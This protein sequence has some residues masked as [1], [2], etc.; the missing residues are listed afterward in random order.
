[1]KL[2]NCPCKEAVRPG[3]NQNEAPFLEAVQAY[4]D[5]GIVPFHTPGH[6][7]GRGASPALVESLGLRALRIDVSDVLLSPRYNDSWT[8]ALSA[9]ERLAADLLGAD[10]CYFLANGTSGGVHA[11]V[12][13][14]AAGR[15]IIV[16]RSSHRSVIGAVILADAWPVYVDPVY[17]PELGLWLPPPPAAWERAMDAHPD[18]AAVL[19]T[20]PTYEGVALDLQ[21]VAEAA[22]ARGLAVLVDEAHGAHF[23]LHPALP[24]RALAL[25]ADLSAQSPHKLLGS[26]TQASWLLGRRGRVEQ[27]AVAAVLGVLQ[28]TSPSALL[29]GSLDEA[30]RQVARRGR[31][32]MEKALAA[33]AKVRRAAAALP[34]VDVEDLT[35]RLAGRSS[36]PG[37]GGRVPAA[38]CAGAD[39]TKLLIRVDGAGWNGFAAAAELRRLGVQV[40][41]GTARHVLALATFG[42]DDD[43]VAA[44]TGALARLAGNPP[45]PG[46]PAGPWED[47]GFDPA[48]VFP[49]AA[50]PVMRPRAAALAPSETVP[51]AEAAGRVAS[52]VVSPY[53]P[54]VPVLCPGEQ[55]TADAVEYLQAILDRGG[56]VRGLLGERD[57]PA[58]RVVGA[59]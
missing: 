49:A 24:P 5:A 17:D 4:A 52:D 21:R 51:L 19:V 11:M 29:Y 43:T 9:A 34:G 46:H 1:M 44:L 59:R 57:A 50:E 16:A 41:M 40:E 32:M 14:A 23:G 48:A 53:P 45:P 56:E 22:H 55:V 38:G 13:A 33:A 47:A 37:A 3:L 20:Y 42:D 39:P 6:K 15:K 27:D 25:G 8:A 30:R 36:A 26:L 31:D 12:M 10:Y 35:E 54:G 58:V 18:A 28:T 2:G 7:Q